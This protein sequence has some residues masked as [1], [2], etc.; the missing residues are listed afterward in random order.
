MYLTFLLFKIGAT[1]EI[2]RGERI[3]ILQ[4]HILALFAETCNEKIPY[5]HLQFFHQANAYHEL[6][7]AEQK[8]KIVVI[9]KQG[10]FH[11]DSFQFYP[12]NWNR[13]RIKNF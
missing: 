13:F 8:R 12:E 5:R 2:Q 3:K 7:Q 1:H 11:Q 4:N 10:C 6:F 9:L